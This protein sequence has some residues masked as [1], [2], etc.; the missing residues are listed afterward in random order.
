[1]TRIVRVGDIEIGGGEHCYKVPSSIKETKIKGVKKNTRGR[2][3]VFN[4]LHNA[5]EVSM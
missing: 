2:F 5:E 3:V 1:M 4:T